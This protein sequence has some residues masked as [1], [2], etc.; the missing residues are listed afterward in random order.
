MLISFSTFVWTWNYDE[1]SIRVLL[2]RW[3]LSIFIVMWWSWLKCLS[4]FIF[5]SFQFY[6]IC[7][8]FFMF[9][10]WLRENGN[11]VRFEL[12]GAATLG[13]KLKKFYVEVGCKDGQC[14]SKSSPI[15]IKGGLNRHLSSP[16]HSKQFNMIEEV[17]SSGPK[18]SG[19]RAYQRTYKRWI[20]H[21]ANNTA[22]ECD[23]LVIIYLSGVLSDLLYQWKSNSLYVAAR[24]PKREINIYGSH[25]FTG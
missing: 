25:C 21:E 6:F 3:Y 1:M 19:D 12:L 4:D 22:I 7:L 10:D 2:N 24:V 16:P 5:I 8:F 17:V 23:D 20:W 18:P 14:Y 9:V 11:D 13:L 15:N